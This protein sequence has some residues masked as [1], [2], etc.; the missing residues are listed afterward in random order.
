M[1]TSDDQLQKE[2]IWVLSERTDLTQDEIAKLPIIEKS[3][4]TV[5]RILDNYDPVFD[6]FEHAGKPLSPPNKDEMREEYIERRRD[7]IAELAATSH[8]RALAHT[9]LLQAGK[10]DEI[11]PL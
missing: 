3:Q 11:D 6:G 4:P 9:S 7:A 10:M 8:L 2:L 5:S 1:N